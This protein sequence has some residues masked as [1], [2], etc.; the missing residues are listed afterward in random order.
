VVWQTGVQYRVIEDEYRH[1]Y[2][3]KMSLKN[4][5]NK[6]NAINIA[7]IQIQR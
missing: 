5:V 6:T 1:I 4:T 7:S 2:E 3:I